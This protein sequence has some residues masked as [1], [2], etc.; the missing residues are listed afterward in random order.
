MTLVVLKSVQDQP[1]AR[2]PK[3]AVQELSGQMLSIRE[4][5]LEGR[6]W[7]HRVRRRRHRNHP[8]DLTTDVFSQ[9]SLKER[10]ARP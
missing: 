5:S 6:L 7:R 1:G 8:L 3:P 10:P 4:G 9:Y 2:S